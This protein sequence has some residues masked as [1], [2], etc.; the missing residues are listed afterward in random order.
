MVEANP[1]PDWFDLACL[2]STI[3]DKDKAFENLEK[4]YQQRNN[5]IP[6]LQV[7]PQLDPLRDD[8]RYADLIR[9][10]EGK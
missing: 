3:G 10:V 6:V 7:E 9:R 8:A 1:D 4:A 2:Y 5:R